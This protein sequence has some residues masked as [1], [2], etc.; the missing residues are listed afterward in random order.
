MSASF[1]CEI[2]D[3]LPVGIIV[4]DRAGCAVVFNRTEEELSGRR[5]ENVLGRPFFQEIAPCM[6]VRDLG[7]RFAREIGVKPIDVTLEYGFAPPH[8]P[9]SRDVRVRMRSFES[10]GAPYGMLVLEDIAREL[11]IDRMKTRLNEL[12][13][14]D[15]KNPLMTVLGSLQYVQQYGGPHQSVDVREAFEDGVAGV[16]RLQRMLLNLLDTT[17]LETNVMTLRR[18]RV[19]VADLLRDAERYARKEARL[20]GSQIECEPPAGELWVEIDHEL[21]SRALENL[22]DNAIEHARRVVLSAS[23]DADDVVLEIA[24]DGP[25]VRDEVRERIFERYVQVSSPVAAKTNRGLGLTF[26]RLVSRAHGGDVTLTCPPSGG[27]VFCMHLPRSSAP[28]R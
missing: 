15:M 14:H 20:R 24:D 8:L 21:I 18:E 25:G 10:G 4:L 17:R 28:Q 13:I 27:S 2:F 7:D 11:T 6:A 12:L 1:L 16:R 3:H 9:G 19:D 5:R 22:V 23:A 26:V